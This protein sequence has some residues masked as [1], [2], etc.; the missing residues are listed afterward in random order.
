LQ[1][2]NGKS[3]LVLAIIASLV[4]FGLS[5]NAHAVVPL[6]DTY[7]ADDPDNGDIVFSNG[8]TLTI[9]FDS[10]TNATGSGLISEAEIN[11]NFTDGVGAPNFGTTYSGVWA[12]DSTSL[13]ITI[14]DVTGGVLVIGVDTIAGAAGTNIAGIAGTNADLISIGGDTATLAGDFG[15]IVVA[16]AGG[17]SS[18]NQPPTL[19]VNKYGQQ[20][21]D[22][23]FSYNGNPVDSAFYNTAFPLIGT[24]VGVENVAKLKIYAHRGIDSIRH[25]A[26]A[27]GLDKGQVFGDSNVVIEWDKLWN[28]VELLNV[29]D[30]ENALDNVRVVTSKGQC[31]ED[32]NSNGCLIVEVFHTFRQPLENNIVGVYVWDD[33]RKGWNNYFNDGVEVQGESLNPPKQHQVSHKGEL[34]Q[35]TET[36]KNTAID[37]N[38]NNWFFNKSWEM[39]YVPS[40]KIDDGITLQGYD[41]NH[42]KFSTYQQGQELIAKTI[43]SAVLDGK[44]IQNDSLVDPIFHESKN[45]QRSEDVVLQNRMAYELERAN[46]LFVDKFIVTDADQFAKYWNIHN[47]FLAQ[48]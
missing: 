24:N 10:A 8:D 16:S 46:D 26:L 9:T 4:I 37:E 14:I 1:H 27:F 45:L 13:T 19:G 28:G 35:I 44:V 42:V 2:G 18:S 47:Q 39:E 25:V 7:V 17:S 32:S 20:I 5:E 12:A 23:G 40:G 11:A 29:I 3:K 48:K 22:N 6:F 15:V 21:V 34:I 31:K 43:L 41:R 36:G 30:P 33:L 38:G